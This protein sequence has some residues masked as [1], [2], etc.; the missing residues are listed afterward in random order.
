[1]DIFRK[2][3]TPYFNILILTLAIGIFSCKNG[4]YS[5][6]SVPHVVAFYNVENLFDTEDD[7][8]KN[9]DDF[10]P[11]G[12]LE[13]DEL[14]YQDKLL[15]LTRVIASLGGNNAP[16]I[17]G[18][19]EV[20][21]LKVLE[22]L[23]NHPV[24]AIYDFGII[25]YDSPDAR[26]IDVA[27]LY[28]KR[29]FKEIKSFNIPLTIDN[30]PNF[31]SRDIL[32]VQGVLGKKDTLHFLVNHFPSRSGGAKPSEYKRI[33]AA[34]L[35]RY[36][37]D[38]LQNKSNNP[39]II[40]MGDFNDNPNDVSIINYLGAKSNDA[41][42]KDDLFNPFAPLIEQEIGSYYYRGNWDMLDQIMVSG[43]LLDK[44]GVRYKENS[45][46][47]FGP[48]WLREQEG[49]FITAPFRTYAGNLYLG[50]YSDH[51]PVYIVLELRN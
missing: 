32:Y 29:Y 27:F 14:R 4:Q 28:Q 22:D 6:V 45:A 12:K 36:W 44:N 23:V 25:H 5:K 24:L 10:T 2:T 19:C 30:E 9:D 51:F 11:E 39:N 17:I 3:K 34:S 42:S 40:V 18:L 33:A 41:L 21:N 49:N 8:T 38:S 7:P 43:T 20:E 47:V 13:W 16:T 1:M 35:N 48:E 46:T 50:G 26:G 31:A 37:V 15:K